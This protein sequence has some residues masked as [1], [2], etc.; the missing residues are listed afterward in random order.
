MAKRWT[1]PFVSR[2]SKQCRI[3]IYDPSWSGAVTELSTNNANAPG[4]AAEDPFY[5]EED[6][7]ENLLS[8]I[9]VKTGYIN[10]IE[11][12]FGGLDDLHPTLMKNRYVEVYYG[13]TLV[14]RGYIQQQTFENDWSAAP[15]EVSLP[16]ISPLG[17]AESLTF[18]AE[19]PLTDNKIGYY[20][21]QIIDLLNSSQG[22]KYGRVTFP[23]VD[24]CPEFYG[25]IRPTITTSEKSSFSQARE[26]TSLPYEGNSIYDF[27]EGICNA[28][29]WICHD[30]PDQI[31]FTR[32]D[33]TGNYA[34][35]SVNDLAA[36]TNRQT[37][38]VS[39]PMTLDTYME[40]C[41]DDASISLILPLRKLTAK[42]MGE[43]I[44]SVKAEYKHMR[45]SKIY[46]YNHNGEEEYLVFLKNI[47]IG[48]AVDISGTYLLDSNT[49]TESENKLYLQDNGINVIDMNGK[50]MLVM[51]NLGT[52]SSSGDTLAT[53]YFYERPVV[54][55]D[56][57]RRDMKLKV[58]LTTGE[59]LTTL[60]QG[61][62]ICTLAYEL[63][64]GDTLIGSQNVSY[65]ND[66]YSV[67][68]SFDNVPNNNA[69]RLVIKNVSAGTMWPLLSFDKIE[70]YYKEESYA[71]YSFRSRMIDLVGDVGYSDEAEIDMLM[72]CL[73]I[74]SNQ[75]GTEIISG[76]SSTYR[77]LRSTQDRLQIR[78]QPKSGQSLSMITAYISRIQYWKSAW[79]W[80]LIAMSFNPWNDEYTLTL[81]HSTT[82][83]S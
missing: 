7:D 63:W 5:F 10:L 37:E 74:D 80:R 55:V 71:K 52:W 81:H 70:L 32:F 69:L 2:Q 16:V 44:S 17:L 58:E 45:C 64:C 12:T 22:T 19:M 40:P 21:K 34:Y 31:L 76:A 68:L 61:D 57:E 51:K 72:Q 56:A 27:L 28:Y 15:R 79:R 29:G 13:S 47:V 23:Q 38:S 4:V 66:N 20:M 59:D 30:L 9:R 24:N 1:I 8:V 83:D 26:A 46:T 77:Y 43:V 75:I 36:A 78:M 25:T 39:D 48:A 11:T 33:H 67:E 53:L 14:F 54:G 82:I 73:W 65:I 42:S 35:Y 50:M 3:D 6:D 41:S 62:I 49:V 18:E 60:G